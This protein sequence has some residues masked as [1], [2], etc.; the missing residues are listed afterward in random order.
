MTRECESTQNEKITQDGSYYRN[1]RSR[2]KGILDKLILEDAKHRSFLEKSYRSPSRLP[3]Y[4]V[5]TPTT[6]SRPSACTTSTGEPYNLLSVVLVI[7]SSAFPMVLCPCA[8]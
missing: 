1:A 8:I 7:T 3:L 6:K 4:Y 5:S 2:Y